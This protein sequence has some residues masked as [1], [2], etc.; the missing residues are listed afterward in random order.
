MESH[1]LV[2][3]GSW[4]DQEVKRPLTAAAPPT[5]PWI[6]ARTGRP[7]VFGR[8]QRVP[9]RWTEDMVAWI[10]QDHLYHLKSPGASVAWK[11]PRPAIMA[12]EQGAG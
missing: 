4:M 6:L 1:G 11:W 12:E 3:L 5:E 8:S 7:C 9:A 10:I 2:A